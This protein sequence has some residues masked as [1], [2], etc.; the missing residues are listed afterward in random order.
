VFQLDGKRVEAA[1]AGE[2]RA[3]RVPLPEGRVGRTAILEVRYQL[4]ANRLGG[5]SLYTPPVLLATAYA[6]PVRWLVSLPPGEVA[7]TTDAA[8]VETRWRWRAGLF[9]PSATWTAE[10]LDRWFRTGTDP[11]AADGGDAV[12]MSLAS[13]DAV[14]VRRIS[15]VGLVVGCSLGAMVLGWLVVRVRGS[16]G[17]VLVSLVAGA[18]AAGV[19]LEPLATQQVVSAAQPGV[20]VLLAVLVALAIARWYHRNRVTHLPGFTRRPAE[21]EPPANNRPRG[22]DT[23]G[24]LQAAGS[25]VEHTT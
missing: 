18:V 17:G 10:E 2:E 20:L 24:S 19:V 22:A 12:V 4:P 13:V 7:L 5:G 23:T 6:G 3:Y 16:A 21:V 1:P 11:T 25:G 15:R 9:R 14:R 8:P